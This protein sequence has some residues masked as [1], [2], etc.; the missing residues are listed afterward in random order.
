MAKWDYLQKASNKDIVDGVM[1]GGPMTKEEQ[2]EADGEP[3]DLERLE[4][5]PADNGG[6][7]VTHRLKDKKEKG[8]DGETHTVFQ[9]PK[10][11]VFSTHSEMMEHVH[12]A[13]GGK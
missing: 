1:K 3:S 9:E 5:E 12:Q 2:R 6:F 13:T 7:S 11:H 8:K 4:I 10:K